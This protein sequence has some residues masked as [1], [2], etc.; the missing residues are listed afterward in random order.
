MIFAFFKEGKKSCKKH[1]SW[2][3]SQQQENFTVEILTSQKET[4]FWKDPGKI[5]PPAGFFW[6]SGPLFA[7][8]IKVNIV[9][10][11]T[12]ARPTEKPEI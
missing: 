4:V 11:A 8:T 1:H 7:V 6:N 5:N 9:N 3:M 10:V 2:K 12:T